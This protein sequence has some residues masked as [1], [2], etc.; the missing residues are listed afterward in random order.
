MKR[1][2]QKL[3]TRKVLLY[4][5]YVSFF[6]F[7]FVLF[8]Y[9]T[10]PYDRLRD[11][12]V[13]EVERPAGPDGQRR[14]SGVELEIAELSPSWVTG[15]ELEGVRVVKHPEEPDG[16]PIEITLDE[17]SA[18][19]GVFSL[20]SGETDL[21]FDATVGGGIIE[22]QY[23]ETETTTHIEAE[24]EEVQLRQLGVAKSLIG[25]PVGGLANGQVLLTISDDNSQTTGNVDLSIASLQI[26]GGQVPVPGM[27]SGLT[28]ERIDAGT[29]EIAMDVDDGVA[30]IE[31]LESDGEDLAVE[32][33]GTIRLMRPLKM[34][35]LDLM[36]RVAFSE[37]YRNRSDHTRRLFSAMDFVPD[38]RAA[39]TPDG[40]LQWRVNGSFGSRI[41]T[42]PAGRARPGE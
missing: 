22:G 32:G 1:F 34:S 39:K 25:L 35:R 14:P 31:K 11:Y 12:I 3:L 18:R 7:C 36:L 17:V 6:F 21:S 27:S 23:E 30:R 41:A 42:S 10:F 37:A 40:A 33:S 8:A 16:S 2:L 29:L 24:L 28:V 15:V 13:Q 5:G 38:L 26:G 4:V 20:L 9:W 19:V